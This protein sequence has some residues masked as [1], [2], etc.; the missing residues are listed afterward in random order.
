LYRLFFEKNPNAY[1][2]IGALL[3]VLLWMNLVSQVLFFG[4]ELCKVAA[5]GSRGTGRS[6]APPAA[7]AA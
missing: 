1:G 5:G 2:A 4:G 3:A 6:G 7:S